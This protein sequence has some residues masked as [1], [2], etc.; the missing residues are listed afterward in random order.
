MYKGISVKVKILS[1]IWIENLLYAIE[2][3]KDHGI[4][5]L[6]F[7]ECKIMKRAVQKLIDF[8]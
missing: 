7:E 3:A 6:R 5:N 4:V 2:S 8:C 1:H